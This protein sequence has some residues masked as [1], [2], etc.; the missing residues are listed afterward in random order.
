[1]SCFLHRIHWPTTVFLP[2]LCLS[3]T[4]AGMAQSTPA[5]EVR[6]TATR[7]IG[8]VATESF[9]SN[10]G[11][12]LAPGWRFESVGYKR[13]V[14]RRRVIEVGAAGDA[15]CTQPSKGQGAVLRGASPTARGDLIS[16]SFAL[17]PFQWVEVKVTYRRESG[18]PMAFV[19]LRPTKDRAQVDLEFLPLTK[20]KRLR[21]A[22][23]RLHSGASKGPYS[24]ALSI[25][26]EGALQIAAITASIGEAYK[27]PTKPIFVLDIRTTNPTGK[28]NP[29]IARVA[30]VFG[31]PS[32]EYLH[33]SEFSTS[34]LDAIDPAVIV[35]PGL[36]SLKGSKRSKI[37]AAVREAVRFDAP[38]VGVCLGHQVLART[39]GAKLRRGTAEWGPTEIRVVK[40]DR[41]FDGLPRIRSFH[42]SESHRFEV[43]RAVGK[44]ELIASS[45]T[46]ATQVFRYRGKRWY[47]F[48]GHIERGWEVASPEA[49]L[50]WK[51]MLREWDVI[52]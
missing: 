27:R 8:D 12:R 15:F 3:V 37:D 21:T 10:T 7:S 34:K 5:K 25:G 23:V 13:D 17:A 2:L 32:V 44:M 11:S 9:W 48:Q 45:D 22:T 38:V 40:P 20:S 50:L 24:L 28:P 46:C 39:Q 16:P 1:M 33:Y 41:L 31:F 30:S 52:E 19:G 42:A 29:N 43:E 6:S 36:V 4:S 35:L 14:G 51:N 26:G 18:K 47:T 49:C